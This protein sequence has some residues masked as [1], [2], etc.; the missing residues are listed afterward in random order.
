M[1]ELTCG[2]KN[3][4]GR[5][6]LYNVDNE[7][8]PP[9]ERA[10]NK[11]H[12]LLRK[13]LFEN[14][15]NVSSSKYFKI[16]DPLQLVTVEDDSNNAIGNNN[17]RGGK[18]C[19]IGNINS[20]DVLVGELFGMCSKEEMIN[21]QQTSTAND[22][23]RLSG[24][25]LNDDIEAR[26]VN[27]HLAVKSFQRSDA[28]RVFHKELVRSVMWCRMVVRRLIVY[29]IEADRQMFGYLYYKN[30][31]FNNYRYI[32]IYNFLRDRLRAVW[33]DLTVQHANRH[34]GSIEC[35]E[36]SFRFLLLSEECLCNVKE[37]NSV[38]NGSL[39][40]TCLGKLMSG[41]QDVEYSKKKFNELI[42]NLEFMNILIYDSPYQ[43][44]FWSYRILTSM[45]INLKNENSSDTRIIDIIN[46]LNSRLSDNP[47]IKLALDIHCSFRLLNIVRY[48]RYFRKCIDIINTL[49][50]NS[51]M[52]NNS[53]KKYS[54]SL[55]LICILIKKYSNII[56]LKYLT[57]LV[58]S[59]ISRKQNMPL[60]DFIE[61]FGI[62]IESIE[63]LK[64]FT[65]RFGIHIYRKDNPNISIF[66]GGNGGVG[67]MYSSIRDLTKDIEGRN[68]NNCY[69]VS[70]RECVNPSSFDSLSILNS[71][72]FPSEILSSLF[73]RIQRID[74][75]DPISG[76]LSK[77]DFETKGSRYDHET[78]KNDISNNNMR[79]NT[80]FS[81]FFDTALTAGN[82]NIV[83]AK[84]NTDTNLLIRDVSNIDI[85]KYRNGAA[86]IINENDQ[87]NYVNNISNNNNSND[88]IVQGFYQNSN[89]Q[90]S[91][92]NSNNFTLNYTSVNNRN[93]RSIYQVED[94]Y[95]EDRHDFENNILL[96]ETCISNKNC[97]NHRNSDFGIYNNN[98]NNKKR[99]FINQVGNNNNSDNNSDSKNNNTAICDNFNRVIL[100]TSADPFDGDSKTSNDVVS[101][102]TGGISV[103]NKNLVAN[104]GKSIGV[105]NIKKTNGDSTED[106]NVIN[107]EIKFKSNESGDE[108]LLNSCSESSEDFR[109]NET[110]KQIYSDNLIED[111]LI[112]IGNWKK[113]KSIFNYQQIM[114]IKRGELDKINLDKKND[115]D[116]QYKDYITCNNGSNI[117]YYPENFHLNSIISSLDLPYS[118]NGVNF[119]LEASVKGILREIKNDI[120]SNILDSINFSFVFFYNQ[121]LS[122]NGI[123]RSHIN[124]LNS[125]YT[126]VELIL[127]NVTK[128]DEGIGVECD[129]GEFVFPWNSVVLESERLSKCNESNERQRVILDLYENDFIFNNS[130]LNCIYDSYSGNFNSCDDEY[131]NRSIPI[132]VEMLSIWM[133]YNNFSCL[134]NRLFSEKDIYTINENIKLETANNIGITFENIFNDYIT[135]N[136]D[137][138][139]WTLPFL[140]N[141][142]FNSKQVPEDDDYLGKSLSSF[143]FNI[144]TVE[145]K[146]KIIDEFLNCCS[147]LNI[148]KYLKKDVKLKIPILKTITLIFS[149]VIC[150]QT[151]KFDLFKNDSLIAE[152]EIGVIEKKLSEIINCEYL[153][154][155]EELVIA[156]NSDLIQT[157]PYSKSVKN[158]INNK[159]II[160]HYSGMSCNFKFKCVGLAPTG[161]IGVVNDA[162][163]GNNNIIVYEPGISSLINT[164]LSFGSYSNNIK[165]LNHSVRNSIHKKNKE[166]CTNENIEEGKND[167]SRK[168]AAFNE[169]TYS[170]DINYEGNSSSE[171]IKIDIKTFILTLL[172]KDFHGID[173]KKRKKTLLISDVN[174]CE[175]EHLIES[176]EKEVN[177]KI[178]TGPGIRYDNL[179]SLFRCSIIRGFIN[180]FRLFTNGNIDWILVS[181]NFAY[182]DIKDII[183]WIYHIYLYTNNFFDEFESNT[184]SVN[185]EHIYPNDEYFIKDT[186]MLGNDSFL[187]Q[188]TAELI[189]LYFSWISIISKNWNGGNLKIPNIIW[190]VLFDYIQPVNDIDS[191]KNK[192]NSTCNNNNHRIVE[193]Y[194]YFNPIFELIKD[195]LI[196]FHVEHTKAKENNKY[197]MKTAYI[198]NSIINNSS[199]EF[200]NYIDRE[201][202][203]YKAF[204][205]VNKYKLDN[206]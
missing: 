157:N 77:M 159:L 148:N 32:D 21:K 186:E 4:A 33:Q 192:L 109:I 103:G 102:I 49:M 176:E 177:I 180:C 8:V 110:E 134:R 54:H 188:T 205:Y 202:I 106:N 144:S 190:N 154:G 42:D 28:S 79:D 46:S 120:I 12:P 56:R 193:S 127:S 153:N 96:Q 131:F 164:K 88:I 94:Y 158:I 98:I 108:T 107:A 182:S 116:T 48:F 47:L 65:E 141:N 31:G 16:Q 62:Y 156:S 174:E 25:L 18:K 51:K 20:Q 36:I 149:F 137:V 76:L 173:D 189:H 178:A 104:T 121:L 27:H 11:F 128:S 146:Q 74:I 152:N 38:Q 19:V 53:F 203:N 187:T 85:N 37:F 132:H 39:M 40:S 87:Q 26:I 206:F 179:F 86:S 112:G 67:S 169:A 2:N 82:R 151:D 168:I 57:I 7:F 119:L 167:S 91:S 58:S 41:Y 83:N 114:R 99:M 123:S 35:Y 70:F 64:L 50:E 43:A 161:M 145:G 165:I 183:T 45:N 197:D 52:K 13:E 113:H 143:T 125:F 201:L 170:N 195:Y 84:N 72:S 204:N 44:E 66:N 61:I 191:I 130:D 184:N 199:D 6:V 101:G 105:S 29:F 142:S 69:I 138:V 147:V 34:R 185:C 9:I 63:Y 92:I 129:S 3:K 14:P 111:N 24:F 90:N 175:H 73:S 95:N 81:N 117:N 122:L 196:C 115:D 17:I 160:S 22:F 71:L 139:V 200:I 59:N 80:N 10:Y 133:N 171:L 135:N 150:I 166:Y 89:H 97:I 5:D 60:K 126:K 194:Y 78:S 162:N 68:R 155:N 172:V 118:K 136:G 124:S 55:I 181:S 198:G 1:N 93:K 163:S 75:L 23:E 30:I 100:G 140:V 15:E